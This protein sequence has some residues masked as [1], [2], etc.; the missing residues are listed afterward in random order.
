MVRAAIVG[1]GSWGRT[2]V[3]AVQGTS[4]DIRFTAAHTRSAAKAQS[5][6]AEHGLRL[7]SDFESLLADP[8]VDAIVLATPNSQHEAQ[9]IQA[10]AA[11]KH[12]FVEKPFALTVAGARRA[13][14]AAAR[15]RIT[16]AVGLNRRFHPSMRE[17]H[18]RVTAGALGTVGTAIAEL[19]ATNGFYRPDDSWRTRPEEEPAGAMASIGVHLVDAM[20][21]MLG[22]VRA[23]HCIA[24]RRG[25]PHGADS[26]SLL[27]HF[28]SGATGLAY[29]SVV[30]ARNFRLAVYGTEGFAEVVKPTMD[31][32]RYIPAV[33]G[34][35]SHLATIPEPE[36]LESPPFNSVAAELGQFGRAIRERTPYPIPA[37]DVLHG[38]EVLAAAVESSATGAPVAIAPMRTE[39]EL[40][41]S[42]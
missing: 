21:W 4:P 6:C 13:L 15:A 1:L 17:L 33:Q 12:V 24:E 18:R 31:T 11:G 19:T 29:C 5:F 38:V 41:I 36:T 27:L 37:A 10:A 40:W 28:A 39:E 35:A 26:T 16:L 42:D 8:A 14:D 25:G 3:A 2:L 22:R 9:V 30:A 23:V 20:I 32:F 34:R 7:A